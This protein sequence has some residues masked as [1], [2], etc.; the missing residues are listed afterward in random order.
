MSKQIKADILLLLITAIWGISFPLMR[1][2]IDNM[3]MST[4]LFMRFVTASMVLLL[5]FYRKLKLL[6]LK[7]IMYSL[8]LGIMLFGTLFFTVKALYYTTVSNVA[9]TGQTIIQKFTSPIHTVL[10]FTFEPVFGVLFSV[11]IPKTNGQKEILTLSVTLGCILILSGMLLSEMKHILNKKCS[12][13]TYFEAKS[14]T[15][16]YPKLSKKFSNWF[17]QY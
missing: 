8:V 15:T 14:K 9:F 6:S 5:L 4:Y 3:P 7:I 12:T 11:L 10:I 13:Y 2:V 1:N 17:R 16:E